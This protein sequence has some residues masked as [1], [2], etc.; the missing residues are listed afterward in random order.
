MREKAMD[1]RKLRRA[2]PNL[3]ELLA[4]DMMGLV[5]R[6]AGTDRAGLRALLSD[7]AGRLP[8]ERF[9]VITPRC[10]SPAGCGCP[11]PAG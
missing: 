5:T 8:V 2:E 9:A 1:V 4:D 11:Q 10:A 7:M 3:E 6:S